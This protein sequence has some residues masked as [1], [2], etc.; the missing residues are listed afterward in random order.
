MRVAL[1][2]MLAV[3]GCSNAPAMSSDLGPMCGASALRP[4][5]RKDVDAVVVPATRQVIVYG[6]DQAPFDPTGT[7]PKSLIDDV[8]RFDL[9]CGTWEKL[10]VTGTAGPRA[11]YAAA[12]DSRRNRMIIMGGN[13]GTG[14]TP[15]LTA[16]VW[17]LDVTTLA[18]TQLQP[19][20]TAPSTRIGHRMTYDA[21]GDRV[22]LFGGTK[23]RLNGPALGD[24][25]SLA[26]AAGPDGA[27]SQLTAAGAAGAPTR[28]YDVSMDVD[29]KRGLLVLFGGA[30]SFDVYSDEVWAFD[31][32]SGA[33]R[34]VPA[35]GGALPSQR[36][37]GKGGWDPARDKLW[38]FGG[39]DGGALGLLNDTWTLALDGGGTVAT[40]SQVLGGDTALVVGGAD[41]A[42]PERRSKGAVVLEGNTL[43]S[44][45]G[46]GDCGPLDDTA[47]LDL[48]APT[49]WKAVFNAQV[50]ETCF[51]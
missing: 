44:F 26:F 1:L 18:W 27:W 25:Q 41:P 24:L 3:G 4:P 45:A 50:G 10:S 21:A 33:W 16:D 31:L 22:L 49:A 19:A 14:A 36:F 30:L 38:M 40:F 9:A 20:G 11:G 13:A 46:G 34:L 5:G 47:T 39:H 32:A 8:W 37:G 17:A 51:R 12:F 2:C 6:G 29:P 48:A 42:S 7:P 28:R 15:P 35:A 43:F 23:S